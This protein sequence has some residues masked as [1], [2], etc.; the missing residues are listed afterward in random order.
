MKRSGI[1]VI[2]MFTSVGLIAF[3]VIFGFRYL[4]IW[5]IDGGDAWRYVCPGC[6]P[7]AWERAQMFRDMENTWLFFT[8]RFAAAGIALI[9]GI[10]GIVFG[11]RL[12]RKVSLIEE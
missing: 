11:C 9:A 6:S 3:G 10:V 1:S 4:W 5:L 12:K 2:L 8:L 7:Q